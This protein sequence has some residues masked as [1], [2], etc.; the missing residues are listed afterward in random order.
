MR[1]KLYFRDWRRTPRGRFSQA[2]ANA[3][4][5]KRPH[6]WSLSYEE[7][8]KLVSQLCYY[9]GGSLPEVGCGLDRIDNK[10]GYH[11]DNVLPACYTC[12]RIRS[13]EFSVD[14]MLELGR[15]I[16]KIKRGIAKAAA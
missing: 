15:V 14:E 12:N 9:C 3:I 1:D 11:L 7:F 10:K 4:C 16:G 2:R 13:D 8:N 5:R 6:D